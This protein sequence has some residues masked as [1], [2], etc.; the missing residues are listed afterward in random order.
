MNL[1]A[2]V[3]ENVRALRKA[4]ALP[5]DELAHRADIHPTYLSGIE[6]GRKNITLDVLERIGRALGVAEEELVRTPGGSAEK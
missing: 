3:A 6:N 5:Q 2:A 1:R 4:R